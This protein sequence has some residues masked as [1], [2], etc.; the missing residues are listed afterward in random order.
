[1][2]MARASDKNNITSLCKLSNLETFA[3]F[4]VA[5]TLSLCKPEDLI[6]EK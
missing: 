3:L 6:R 4:T 5:S 2:A 1:M